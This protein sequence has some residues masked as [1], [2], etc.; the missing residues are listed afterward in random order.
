ML[1]GKPNPFMHPGLRGGTERITNM[2]NTGV[3]IYFLDAEDIGWKAAGS[4]ITPP[5]LPRSAP[6]PSR[7]RR[8][9]H[10]AVPVDGRHQQW[11]LPEHRRATH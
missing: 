5:G 1:D 4:S 2:A 10:P 3:H 7:P 9:G 8:P 6:A 11:W